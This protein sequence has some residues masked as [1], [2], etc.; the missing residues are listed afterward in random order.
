MMQKQV[1]TQ[2]QREIVQMRELGKQVYDNVLRE[3]MPKLPVEVL[4]TGADT[5]QSPNFKF[6]RVEE[7]KYSAKNPFTGGSVDETWMRVMKG[8]GVTVLPLIEYEG[9]KCPV[10]IFKPQPS[11]E[12]WSIELVSGGVRGATTAVEAATI[13][14]QQETG[15]KAEKITIIPQLEKIWHAPHRINTIDTMVIAENITFAGRTSD[16]KEEAP[17]SPFIATWKEVMAYLDNN[18]IKYGSSV[19]TLT[20]YLLFHAPEKIMKEVRRG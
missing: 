19:A 7:I 11:V 14:L 16:E 13:E 17:I 10:L 1:A 6:L 20:T 15:L 9:Q 4:R 3:G 18:V 5:T 2:S 12:S 8:F